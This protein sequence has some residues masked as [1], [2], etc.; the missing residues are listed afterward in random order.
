MHDLDFW[1]QRISLT[2]DGDT[3]ADFK[4]AL[5]DMNAVVNSIRQL[6]G[7]RNEISVALEPGYQVIDGQQFN[8][9]IAIPSAQFQR[10]LFRAYIP[11]TG[12]PVTLDLNGDET[13]LCDS[14]GVLGEQVAKFINSGDTQ[15]H[16]KI[17]QR[18]VDERVPSDPR[19]VDVAVGLVTHGSDILLVYNNKWAAFTLPMTKRRVWQDPLIPDQIRYEE[20][21]DAAVRAVSEDIGRTIAMPAE[22][23]VDLDVRQQSDR[24][25]KYKDYHYHVFRFAFDTL[26]ELRLGKPSQWL[27]TDQVLDAN[28]GPITASART[29]L[30]ELNRKERGES[31][32]E[33]RQI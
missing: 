14:P 33:A 24:D 4:K 3:V 29:I 6:F 18:I 15:T 21:K 27:T 16:L 13:V 22:F 23:L 19:Q 30:T 12:Y 26:P 31:G 17:V 11:E 9:I 7:S 28:R 32:V 25:G 8:V 1:L 10:T 20:L 5:D 2:L